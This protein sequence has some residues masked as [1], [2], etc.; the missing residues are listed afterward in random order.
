MFIEGVIDISVEW[1]LIE[2][3]TWALLLLHM[4]PDFMQT[5]GSESLMNL[6]E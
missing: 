3:L 2:S 1:S 5:S 6:F 4:L